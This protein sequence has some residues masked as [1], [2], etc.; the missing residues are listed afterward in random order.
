MF[1]IDFVRS[2]SKHLS[3]KDLFICLIVAVSDHCLI[4]DAFHDLVISFPV[5]RTD[6]CMTVPSLGYYFLVS[7]LYVMPCHASKLDNRVRN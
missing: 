4:F 5:S 1:F 7:I 6:L 2:W 3:F